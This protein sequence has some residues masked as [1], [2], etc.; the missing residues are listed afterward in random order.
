[1]RNFS[2]IVLSLAMAFGLLGGVNSVK[3]GNSYLEITTDE[4]GSYAWDSQFWYQL[5]TPLETSTTYVL[6]MDVKCSQAFHL[7]FWPHES[8]SDKCIYA[9]YDVDTEWKS[10]KCEFSTGECAAD[11]VRWCFG[12]LSGQLFFDNIKLVKKGDT[13]NLL[14]GSDFETALDNH[15]SASSGVTFSEYETASNTTRCFKFVNNVVKEHNYQSTVKYDLDNALTSG[16]SYTLTMRAKST[17]AFSIPFW[18]SQSGS[19][20]TT[21]TGYAIG[22]EWADCSCTFTASDAHTFL[23]WCIGDK[24]NCTVWFDDVKLV[25]EGSSTNLIND[26]GFDGP[27]VS[28]WGDFGY[29]KPDFYGLEI[30]YPAVEAEETPAEIQLSKNLF[31][32][33]DKADG[34]DAVVTSNSPY[35][36]AVGCGTDLAAGA[37]IYGSSNVKYLDYADLSAYS[38][39]KIYGTGNSVR[40]MINRQIGGDL[41]ELTVSPTPEGTSVDI[42]AYLSDPGYFHLNAIKVNW[43]GSA[44]ITAV[45]LLDPNSGEYVLSGDIKDGSFS[46]SA[47]SALADAKAKVIDLTGVTGSGIELASAN[48]NCLFVA[49]DGTLT[50]DHNVIVGSSCASLELVDNYPFKAPSN[51]TATAATFETTINTTAKAGTLCLPYAATIPEGVK[52]WTLNYS[53]GDKVTATPVATTIPANTPVLLNGSGAQSFTGSSVSVT[54]GSDNT[55]GAL[56]GVFEEGYVPKDSYVLQNGASGLAFYKVDAD[57]KIKVKSFRAYLT[58]ESASSRINIEFEDDETTGVADINR[59]TITNNGSFYNLNGQRVAQPAKG[60]YIVNGKMVVIK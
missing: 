9:G 7:D 18:P 35:W 30:S 8:T 47:T 19:G 32:S 54:A 40:V 28:N 13:S 27:M 14:S 39:L 44:T 4:A 60:L 29:H 55:S 12:T 24:S 20:N 49:N 57:N 31:K 2:K 34:T 59:E 3:A 56:T 50:N 38:G 41:T 37:V 21:Y 15:W 6:T 48:P 22:T 10:Y 46:A 5:S 43:G 25:E 33:W 17:E 42:S 58:A 1:M 45:I 36:D 11:R 16:K 51:F 26:G 52:A 53:S 23:Q